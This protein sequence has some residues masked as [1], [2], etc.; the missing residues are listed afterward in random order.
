MAL[1]SKLEVLTKDDLLR[2]HEATLKILRETGVVFHSEEAIEIFKKN[3]AR[4]ENK[5]VFISR[6]MVDQALATAPRTFRMR[7][8][9]EK[10][11][12][13]VGEGFLIQPNVGPVYIQDLD[14]GRREATLEDYANIQKLCQASDVVD[15]AGTIPVDPSDVNSNDKYLLMMYEALKNTEKPIIGFCANTQQVREQ[16]DMVEIALGQ[17]GFLLENHCTAV[18]VN[19]LSP[20]AYAP[21]TLETMIEYAKRNQVILLAPCIMA[22]VSGPISL[23]GTAVLQNTETI[24]G[25]VLVQLVNPGTPL[26]YATAS[27]SGYM[28]EATYAAGSPEAML[29][30]TASLQM[31][32]DFYHLP[33]RTMS[34]ITHSKTVDCQ[35]GYETMQSLLMGMMSGAQ[36]SVQSLG[37]LDAIMTTSYEK[38]VID[39]ELIRRVRRISQGI[40]TSDEALSVDVIQEVG[41]TGT[42]LSHM[43][44]FE[45]FRS[46]WTPT[47]S[48]WGNYSD[49]KSSGS[50]DVVIRANRRYK[51]ILQNAP[52]S[53]LD[54][55]IDKAILKF[56]EKAK[57]H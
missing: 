30:N 37:V 12:I 16:L 42:Y 4:V 18:L 3:G 14:R 51:Q 26:V 11:S 17:P 22:G 48:D 9:N 56:I 34:G 54:T 19:S 49:W 44:T 40:D 45:K 2:V 35:A 52:E 24:A 5:T 33:V 28:K 55:A 6:E 21:D 43:S 46:L 41:H 53:L 27:T 38:F 32:L 7:A 39:E 13:T 57:A 31:G 10:Y 23:L 20:L 47:V 36:M 29:I 25:L 1:K 8:R 50:E 15:L